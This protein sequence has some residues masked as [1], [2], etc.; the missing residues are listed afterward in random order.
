VSTTPHWLS[1]AE[2]ETAGLT[3]VMRQV[4]DAKRR[5][6]D[7]L[8]F[9]RL[10]DFYELFFEDALQGSR[11][12]DLTLTS[13]NRNDPRPI[14]MCGFPHH[15]ASGHVQ[16]ALEAGQRCAIV[17]QLQD[18]A[19]VKG[20]VERGVTHVITPGVVLES[21]AL[22][23]QRSN[24]LVALVPGSRGGL[25]LAACDASTG[26]LSTA[27]VHHPAALE[28]LLTRLEPR[29]IVCT[30]DVV[31]WLDASPSALDVARSIRAPAP[32]DRKAPE[33]CLTDTALQLLRAYLD[34]VRPN[35]TNWLQAPQ[36][37]NETAHLQLSRETVLHLELLTTARLGRRQGALL[38][39]IDRTRTAPGARWL[40]TLLLAPLAD[41]LQ[42][43]RRHGAVAELLL[44]RPIRQELAG[45][46][47]QVC[48]VARVATRAAA[49]MAQPRELVAL[50]QTLVALP[51]LSSQLQLLQASP[52]LVDLADQL[53]GCE[54]LAAHLQQALADQPRPT[55]V[56]GGVIRPGWDPELD[57]YIALTEREDEW[58]RNFEQ[59]ERATSGIAS[60]RVTY[61]R[62]T[63]YGI[64]ITRSKSEQV[65]ARYHR[66]QTLKNVERYQTPELA[67]FEHKMLS[68]ESDRVGREQELY[69]GL[70]AAVA[71]QRGPLRRIGQLLAE[72]DVHV[73]FAELAAIHSY[74][75]PHLTDDAVLWLQG[76]RHPVVEQLLPPGQ[77]V[78]N[79][80]ALSG[81]TAR[82]PGPESSD[83]AQVLLITGP[84]MAGKSTLMRQAA[85]AVI[86][87]QIGS[88]V[89]AEAAVLG[90]FDTV[91]TRIGAGDDIADGASTFLVEM[92]ET[93][94]ILQR[95]TPRSLVLLDEVGR[96]TSTWDGLA[97]AWAVAERLHDNTEAL[98]L[99]ATHY[100]ELTQLA[101]RLPRLRN[102]HVAVQQWGGEIVFV[103]RLQPG[104]TSRSH[105]I[106]VAKLA[107]LPPPVV[108]RAQV[109][110]EQ[111]ERASRQ[112]Q[113]G[114]DGKPTR[115]IGL[116]DDLPTTSPEP[117][118]AAAP[119]PVPHDVT[120]EP[121]PR[122]LTLLEELAAVDVDDLTPRE[123]HARLAQWCALAKQLGHTS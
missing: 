34:E 16:R 89:P 27:E 90:V 17:E 24:H 38:A 107:G 121:D 118:A 6:P 53:S 108:Q 67:E 50:R 60:L 10:G 49:H 119:A 43:E 9:F 84:N 32:R 25:G 41:R 94:A 115:Q 100:H 63:G 123:A 83:P 42:L 44:Q 95:A 20:I 5:H 109:V 7:A 120:T 22:D 104:P 71:E 99:F 54:A 110:L 114:A 66:K 87:S 113:A 85:L 4:L 91:L 102:A 40:R 1:F 35:A 81:K 117:V 112:V 39:A 61:N 96:G 13:R 23:Q 72:L 103:H 36:S 21:E 70:Q 74:V 48:D 80:L 3:A 26:S 14:P 62:N 56:E 88:F 64:E 30:P 2:A 69:R 79:D 77:F 65:P 76:C 122:L 31:A 57:G 12:L 75:R 116:F 28:V 101:L 78:A 111:L 98:T 51:G 86:L 58:M 18:P 93:A 73:G 46:L 82:W 105:G 92:R 52:L 8:I 106:A 33:P 68:A 19:S 11:L 59:Q 37:L 45:L 97:I 47:G 55:V 15:A 29:E